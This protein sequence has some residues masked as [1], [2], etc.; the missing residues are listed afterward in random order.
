MRLRKFPPLIQTSLI[1]AALCFASVSSAASDAP[2]AVEIEKAAES[3][4]RGRAAFRSG[5]FIEAAE[6][7]EAADAY[8]PSSA[9]L[10]LAMLSRARAEQFDRALTL[11]A[12]ALRLYPDEAE[13]QK[14]ATALIG[15]HEAGLGQINIRCDQP[16]KLLLDNKLVHGAEDYERTLYV[17][18]GKHRLRVNWSGGHVR[19]LGVKIEAGGTESLDLIAPTEPVSQETSEWLNSRQDEESDE[20][21]AKKPAEADGGR[22]W[23]PAVFW[24]GVGLTGAGVVATT[25][26]GVRAINEPGVD[27][28]RENCMGNA[29]CPEYQ[30]GLQNQTIANV[31]LGAT[32]AVGVLTVVTG[33]WLTD[34]GGKKK[35]T[36]LLSKQFGK[37]EMQ[38]MLGFADG[39]GL[40]LSGKF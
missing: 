16:C 20:E 40:G 34:W 22:G 18:P 32:V 8:A 23:S 5:G 10:R 4:D 17:T 31:A 14:E 7:F 29:D 35:E 2:T 11:A 19:N 39:P 33:A 13:L 28:V 21:Y 30:Q 6:S 12:L 38:P 15:A 37:V 24:T 27:A 25:I 36:A 26:L 1:G 3:F 9:S